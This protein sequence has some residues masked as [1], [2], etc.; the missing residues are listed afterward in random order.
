MTETPKLFLKLM[1]FGDF[2]HKNMKWQIQ[3]STYLLLAAKKFYIYLT[4]IGIR[5]RSTNNI[6]SLLVDNHEH[7]M[8]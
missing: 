5:S 2:G 1:I 4:Q 3:D 7:T 8:T 6:D